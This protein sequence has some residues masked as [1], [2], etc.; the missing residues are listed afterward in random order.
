MVVDV[1]RKIIGRSHSWDSTA[2]VADPTAGV[3]IAYDAEDEASVDYDALMAN[4]EVLRSEIEQLKRIVYDEIKETYDSIVDALRNKDK[5]TAELLAAEVAVK[6]NLARALALVSK[7]LAVAMARAKTARSAEEVSRRLVPVLALLR[8]MSPYLTNVSPEIAL[9]VNSIRDEIERLYYMPGVEVGSVDTKSVMEFIPEAKSILRQAAQEVS[10]ELDA[11]I[12][13]I[14]PVASQ[15]ALDI[16]ALETQLIDYIR[17]NGGRV[18]V[19]RAAE[20][21]GVSPKLIRYLLARLEEKGV[22]KLAPA[23]RLA[24][25]A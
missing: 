4:L 16:E 24:E 18:N 9:Q 6:K 11:N 12:P 10:E 17:R 20:A 13:E 23:R 8:S 22:I 7:L 3:G 5:E 2:S 1:L 25:T 15:P 19:R 21:L 14:E